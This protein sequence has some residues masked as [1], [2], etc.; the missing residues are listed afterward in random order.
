MNSP[1]WLVNPVALQLNATVRGHYS[2]IHAVPY[3][4]ITP[5]LLTL[6]YNHHHQGGSLSNYKR[7]E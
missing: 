2:M 6:E 4:E 1:K 3:P 5:I 7:R